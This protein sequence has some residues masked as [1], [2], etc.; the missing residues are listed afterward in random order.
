MVAACGLTSVAYEL[1][2][3]ISCGIFPDKVLNP[4][5][6]HWQVD[7]YHWAT[8]KAFIPFLTASP[9]ETLV[10]CVLGLFSSSHK[11]HILSSVLFMFF[12]CLCFLL[13]ICLLTWFFAKQIILAVFYLLL[14]LFTAFLIFLAVFSFV[15]FLIGSL[16]NR[17]LCFVTQFNSLW[18]HEL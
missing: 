2:C 9:F 17:S 11:C 13:D 6:L 10:S 8:S 1:S 14:N 7:L 12:V 15:E 5:L 16:F 18:P 3:P 4:C